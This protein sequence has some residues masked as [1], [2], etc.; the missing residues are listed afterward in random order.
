[1]FVLLFAYDFKMVFLISSFPY[2]VG[3]HKLF[4]VLFLVCSI[5]LW[6]YRKSR[7]FRYK[8]LGTIYSLIRQELAKEFDGIQKTL[9]DQ[10]GDW[11]ERMAALKRLQGLALGR[12]V[13]IWGPAVCTWVQRYLG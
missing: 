9:S 10:R 7:E 2:L 11:K 8:R 3:S 4:C 6:I 1:M 5:V 13:L 12:S